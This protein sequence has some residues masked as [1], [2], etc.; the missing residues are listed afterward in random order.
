M[1]KNRNNADIGECSYVFF[2][3]RKNKRELKKKYPDHTFVRY[4]SASAVENRI[5]E[6]YE[7]QIV[8][9]LANHKLQRA[10]EVCRRAADAEV[11][12][13]P[14]DFGVSGQSMRIEHDKPRLDYM[15]TEIAHIC[16]L[17]CKGCSDFLNLATDERYYDFDVFCRDLYRL[18]ELFWGVEKI[19]LM[20]GEPILNP[21]LVDYVEKTREIFPDCDLRIVTNGLLISS[22]SG[23]TLNRIKNCRCS[24]DISSYPPTMKK[25]REIKKKL[26]SAG[27]SFIFSVPMRFF[28]RTLLEHPASDGAAAFRNCLFSHCHMMGNGFLAPCSYAY[29]AYRMNACFQTDFPETDK[30]DLSAEKL[31]GWQI[32]ASFKQPHAFCRYCGRGMIPFLWKGGVTRPLAKKDDWL[33]RPNA[34]S[35]H[36]VPFFQAAFVPGMKKLRSILQK[37]RY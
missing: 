2:D 18:K 1:K 13:I 10:V 34:L 8:F 23:E 17:N 31:D 35:L 15:E 28:F 32:N 19:R 7:K 4:C 33:I 22:L 36:I 11:F 6:H 30:I 21:R 3:D 14:D 26:K 16:N 24:F 27:V 20:G 37:K 5:S 25:K 9:S 12:V 29:C